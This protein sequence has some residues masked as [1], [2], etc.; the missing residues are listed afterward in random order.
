MHKLD[1]L[2][3][4]QPARQARYNKHTAIGIGTFMASPIFLIA[5]AILLKQ[6]IDQYIDIDLLGIGDLISTAAA[7]ALCV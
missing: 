5:I 1:G 7:A 4:P 6:A 3:N 2:E